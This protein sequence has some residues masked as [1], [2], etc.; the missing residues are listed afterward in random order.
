MHIN[1]QDTISSSDSYL[2]SLN[3]VCFFLNLGINFLLYLNVCPLKKIKI[4]N[5]RIYDFHIYFVTLES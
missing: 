1:T 2:F 3:K 5:Y 4:K